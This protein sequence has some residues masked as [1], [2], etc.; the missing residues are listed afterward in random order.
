MIAAV[1][2]ASDSRVRRVS[3]S[4]AIRHVTTSLEFQNSDFGK[5]LHAALKEKSEMQRNDGH[6]VNWQNLCDDDTQLGTRR[7]LRELDSEKLIYMK[8]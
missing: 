3:D 5:P 1:L 4:G 7:R 6:S 8:E 2:K